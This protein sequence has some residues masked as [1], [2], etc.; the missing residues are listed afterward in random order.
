MSGSKPSRVQ[1]RR[2]PDV[3]KRGERE[4]RGEGKREV[5]RE[6][7]RSEEDSGYLSLKLEGQKSDPYDLNRN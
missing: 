7:E 2:F 3:E 1:T 5:R 6:K 4:K